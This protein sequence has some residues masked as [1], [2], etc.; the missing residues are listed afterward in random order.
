MPSGFRAKV[1]RRLAKSFQACM[2]M[3][4]AIH[5]SPAI[6]AYDRPTANTDADTGTIGMI[7][8]SGHDVK[9][10]W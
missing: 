3:I 2:A 10:E 8:T 7:F 6:A 4:D 9:S 5:A 1:G